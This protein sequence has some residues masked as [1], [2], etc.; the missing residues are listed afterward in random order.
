MI[1]DFCFAVTIIIF[2]ELLKVTFRMLVREYKQA[3]NTLP[4]RRW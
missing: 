3:T 4:N 1:S 2:W